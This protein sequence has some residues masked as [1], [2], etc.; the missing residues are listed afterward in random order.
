MIEKKAFTTIEL[1]LWILNPFLV[2]LAIFDQRIQPGQF[3][4]WSGKFHPLVLHFPVV[5]GILIVIY[6]LF[7]QK[8]RAPVATEKLMLAINAL[9]ASVTALFGLLLSL[10]D[11]YDGEM[12]FQHKWGGIAVALIGWLFLYVLYL[13][14][15]FKKSLSILL[16]IILLGS[17]HRGAQLTHGV[18][19]LSFPLPAASQAKII[20]IDSTVTVYEA[21]IAPI[22]AQKCI[23]CH[24]PDKT[25]GS[26]QLDSPEN[27]LKGGKNGDI[28][29]RNSS[30]GH[31]FTDRIHLPLADEKHMP[32]EGKTQLT[33][34]EKYILNAWIKS[35]ADFK[36]RVY[37]LPKEDSISVLVNKYVSSLGK[38]SFTHR[39][40]RDLTDFNTNYCSVNYLFSGSGEVEANFFQSSFYNHESLKQLEN[41]KE[42]IVHL[43][44]QGMPLTKEDLEVA[45]QFQNLKKINLN[46]TGVEIGSLEFL[47]T[48]QKLK[49]VSICGIEFSKAELEIFLEKAPFSSLNL[50]PDKFNKEELETLSS[51]YP[52]L[53]IVVGENFE[54][55]IMK[56]T[57]PVIE[58]D[59]TFITN[60]L[61]VKIKHLLK[62]VEIRYTTNGSEPDS[63]NSSKY[64]DAIRLS[65]NSILKAKAFKTGWI[66]SDIVKRNFYKAEF[67]PD[68]VF[69]LTN[70]DPKYFGE[71]AKMLID[72]ELGENSSSNGKW[73]G[74]KDSNMEFIVGFNQSQSLKSAFINSFVDIGAY[75]FPVKSIVVLG[76]NDGNR[77]TEI[78]GVSIPE[79]SKNEPRGT[80]LLSIEFPEGTSFRKYK[81]IVSNY[82]KLPDW[83]RGK[84]TPAWIFVDEIFF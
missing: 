34:D 29:N 45:A 4:Q 18:N 39:N 59:T 48:L 20:T 82:K 53:K 42:N 52:G 54:N 23:S 78:A 22:L 28:L 72:L 11:A 12:I 6:F 21:G 30:N 50:W 61:D 7:F 63:I 5:F 69:L 26:L 36:A 65:K 76:S 27:I 84:G 73:L 62:G 32:P 15:R 71:G 75:I 49:V 43:N 77:F 10:Q 70:P 51:K 66:G 8:K 13:D 40:L 55:E 17:A 47:K 46:Y 33:P 68:T 31:I 38:E 19:A 44:L 81:F 3:L 83:H 16:L 60:H 79:A 37:E 25:K 2:I 9:L 67:C 35:G 57:N 74:Y 64:T 58:Q 14:H 1:S 80:R 56:L 24:G 41:I